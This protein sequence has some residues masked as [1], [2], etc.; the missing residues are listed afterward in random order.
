MAE[1]SEQVRLLREIL[2]WTRFSGMQGV[3]DAL[4]K[5][6]D[7]EQ[8]RLIY[9]L[10]DGKK[11]SAEIGKAAGV[12]D[13]T[14]R[15]YWKNWARNGLVEAIKAGAGDRYRHSFEVED[16]GIEVPK[17]PQRAEPDKVEVNTLLDTGVR[18]DSA[19]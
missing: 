4:N 10:S 5:M 9:Y 3:K 7:S 2:K 6:L 8:K 16:F 18:E 11:G 14:V 17:I 1:D 13:W 19:Q 15:N 12:S